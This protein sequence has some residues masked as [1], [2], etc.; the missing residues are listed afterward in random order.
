[1]LSGRRLI[2]CWL[3]S[4]LVSVGLPAVAGTVVREILEASAAQPVQTDVIKDADVVSEFVQEN[5]EPDFEEPAF[6]EPQPSNWE[7]FFVGL[8]DELSEADVSR[9]AS[10]R[11][12]GAFLQIQSAQPVSTGATSP[13]VVQRWDLDV[14][15]ESIALTFDDGPH[16]VY[17]PQILDV[18]ARYG[19][20]ATFFVIGDLSEERPE[21]LKRI[22]DE[23]HE[24]GNHG[25]SHRTGHATTLAEYIVELD[26]TRSVIYDVSGQTTRWYRPNNMLMST[27]MLMAC[28]STEHKP[29]IWTVDTKDWGANTPDSIVYALDP[30]GI[31][32]GSVVLMHDGGG[33]REKTVAA[34]ERVLQAMEKRGLSSVTLSE[35]VEQADFTQ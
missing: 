34:L 22:A 14:P 26:R 31:A 3:L 8:D 32:A 21:I 9:Q 29:V 20:K 6:N 11:G 24:L 15:C 33:D 30:N 25:Y 4:L 16:P 27:T 18:L 19:Q 1:M 17:T 5:G 35:L 12:D 7:Q 13:V 2:M 23:G 28:Q 10:L